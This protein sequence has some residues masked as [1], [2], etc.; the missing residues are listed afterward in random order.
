[1][2]RPGICNFDGG[3]NTTTNTQTMDPWL[4]T[5]L[6]SNINRAQTIAD[7]PFTPYSGQGYAP[8]SQNQTYSMQA[9]RDL[10]GAGAPTIDMGINA[11]GGLLGFNA[12]GGDFS[13]MISKYQNPYQQEVIDRAMADMERQRQIA[14]VQDNQTATAAKAFGGSR[15][16]VADSL[17][18]AAYGRQFGDMVSNLRNQGFNSAASMA[19]QEAGMNQV[20]A[21]NSAGVRANAAGMLGQFGQQQFNNALGYTNALAQTGG[22]EQ[23][24]QQGQNAFDYNEFLRQMGYDTQGQQLI[25]SSLDLLPNQ[26]TTTS[27]APSNTTANTLNGI[28]GIGQTAGMLGWNPFG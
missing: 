10:N 5:T 6:S 23:Q 11:A 3:S 25:N 18:N 7:Q 4:K 9:A 27:T 24:N 14:G 21:L 1:V 8:L 22:I 20:G 19:A 15:H 12:P 2:A 13:G 26:G 17:T 16:G 28:M